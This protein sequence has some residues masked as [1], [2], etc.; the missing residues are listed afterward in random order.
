MIRA[1]LAATVAGLALAACSGSSGGADTAA[2]TSQTVNGVEFHSSLT[3]QELMAHVIDAAADGIWLHQGWD[4][5]S[6][7]LIE[8]FPKTD[9]E[10]LATENAAATLAESTNLLLLP[11]HNQDQD[12][13]TDWSMYAGELHEAAMDAM[14]RAEARDK[15]GFFD[16]GGKIYVVCKSCHEKYILGDT[17][18]PEGHLP[19]LS[20]DDA[21]GEAPAQ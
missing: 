16:A 4:T 14:Q 10:W 21:S 3:T 12:G 18:A 9:A 13:D 17:T 6:E 2:G 5:G 19:T 7:G 15:E 20:R 8:L 11:V 1:A